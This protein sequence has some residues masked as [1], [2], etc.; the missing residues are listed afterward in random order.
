MNISGFPLAAGLKKLGVT[1]PRGV[2]AS[3]GETMPLPARVLHGAIDGSALR[4]RRLPLR[5]RRH[6]WAAGA[7]GKHDQRRGSAEDM[8]GCVG[9]VHGVS[10]QYFESSELR[11]ANRTS[12]T[13]GSRN[14]WS[15]RFPCSIIR[16]PRDEVQAHPYNKSVQTRTWGR[17]DWSFEESRQCGGAP[18][19]RRGQSSATH[20]VE[21]IELLAAA[22]GLG[23]LERTGANEDREAPKKPLL[24]LREQPTTPVDQRAHRLL[25]RQVPCGCIR[26]HSKALVEPLRQLSW[27]HARPASAREKFARQKFAEVRGSSRL[28]ARGARCAGSRRR[29]ASLF[30][31]SVRNRFLLT[32]VLT[33]YMS[34]P[35]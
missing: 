28:F 30:E 11:R 25:A 35:S 31:N 5:C 2:E 12:R 13:E 27:R 4:N 19:P 24:L 34:S 22:I 8:A 21:R 15:R 14:S 29:G 6:L 32:N 16:S 1:D 10:P 26:E 3:S 18:C 23:R 7:C 20:R 17:Q 33:K 9:Y